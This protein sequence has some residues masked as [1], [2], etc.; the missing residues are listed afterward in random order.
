MMQEAIFEKDLAN[1]KLII[2]RSF[3]A[4]LPLVWDAWTKSEILD[5]WWAPKPY[6]AE[7]KSQDF[8]EGGMWHYAMVSPEGN[9]HWCRADYKT[10]D[11]Q[12]QFSYIDCFCDEIATPTDFPRMH[13]VNSF[14]QSGDVTDV[15]IDITFEKEEDIQK[16]IEMGFKEGFTMGMDNLDEYLAAKK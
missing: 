12:K 5:E 11:A 6:K 3:N 13:W 9:K 10:I 4:E 15:H 7:T 2:T 14:S 16:I 8:R 1:K